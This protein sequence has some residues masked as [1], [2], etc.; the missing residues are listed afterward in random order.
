[1]GG[2]LTHLCS[3]KDQEDN[4]RDIRLKKN[5]EDLLSIIED[6]N[7]FNTHIASNDAINNSLFD[8]D[9]FLLSYTDFHFH[10]V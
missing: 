3:Q 4:E 1:M 6:Y 5:N 10:Q 2:K 8:H 9:K 7:Y